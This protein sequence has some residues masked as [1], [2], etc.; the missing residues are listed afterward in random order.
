MGS[1]YVSNVTNSTLN[2]TSN[3]YS[4]RDALSAEGIYSTQYYIENRAPYLFNTGC[5]YDGVQNCT[6]A[7]QD[8]GSAFSSLDTLHNCMMY[9]II[10]DQY[11]KNNLSSDSA[12]LAQSLEIEK[13]EWP[14]N[15][16]ASIIYTV[17]SCLGTLMCISQGNCMDNAAL[18]YKMT[19]YNASS[20]LSIYHNSTF[21]STL[22]EYTHNLT[23][24]LCSSLSASVSQD[25]GGIGVRHI[26]ITKSNLANCMG[27]YI[28][29][30]GFKQVSV[31]WGS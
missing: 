28:Y 11:F 27:R 1:F 16:S 23:Y 3:T 24:A 19:H 15:L 4:L 8:P 20:P 12:Q 5:L 18:E 2:I 31:F 29:L 30:I 10:A 9:P 26:L 21:Y 22:V 14:S 7:C 17:S 13:S 6:A 25:I